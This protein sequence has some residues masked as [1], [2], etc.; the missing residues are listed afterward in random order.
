MMSHR[1]DRS[2][3]IKRK[4]L[5][6][7]NTVKEIAWAAHREHGALAG[8]PGIQ[9][10]VRTAAA[11]RCMS[12]RVPAICRQLLKKRGAKLWARLHSGNFRLE[13]ALRSTIS[14]SSPTLANSTASVRENNEEICRLEEYKTDSGVVTSPH[15]VESRLHMFLFFFFFFS[16]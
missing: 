14:R 9:V 13:R 3:K 12:Q 1:P 4:L 2:D 11:P 16:P 10:T 5:V 7:S 6:Q 15:C 8:T